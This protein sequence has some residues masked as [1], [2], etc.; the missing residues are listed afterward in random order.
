MT[1]GWKCPKCKYRNTERDN[2]RC[3]KCQE[4]PPQWWVDLRAGKPLQPPSATPQSPPTDASV[5]SVALVP[6]APAEVT[7]VRTEDLIHMADQGD[8]YACLVLAINSF[9][10]LGGPVDFK[11]S[12]S[13]LERAARSAVDSIAT[14]VAK[15]ILDL[16]A[17]VVNASSALRL[18]CPGHW[19]VQ[20]M[21]GGRVSQQRAF[22]HCWLMP[23]G[24]EKHKEQVSLIV[25]QDRAPEA[26]RTRL[27]DLVNKRGPRYLAINAQFA[28]GAKLAR[29]PCAIV[30]TRAQLEY[31]EGLRL[32]AS[33]P[34]EGSK[35]IG[36]AAKMGHPE[37]ELEYAESLLVGRG[38]D[39]DSAEAIV[40]FHKA[41]AR[42]D[43]VIPQYRLGFVLD[44]PSTMDNQPAEAAK[45][46]EMAAKAG[47][48]DA[49]LRLGR[50]YLEGRGV[51]VSVRQAVEWLSQ[52]AFPKDD[53]QGR[54]SM[55][56]ARFLLV[57]AWDRL[58]ELKAPL[59]V[60]E[61]SAQQNNSYSQLQL[62]WR[63]QLGVGTPADA[64]KARKWLTQA[65][66]DKVRPTDNDPAVLIA[67]ALL[68]N[69]YESMPPDKLATLVRPG[70]DFE[71]PMNIGT[72]AAG[73]RTVECTMLT[74]GSSAKPRV[75]LVAVEAKA[76]D[77]NRYVSEC[78]SLPTAED[79]STQPLGVTCNVNLIDAE[80]GLR[81]IIP[82]A[83]ITPAVAEEKIQVPETKGQPSAESQRI[84]IMRSGHHTNNWLAVLG[85]IDKIIPTLLKYLNR[86]WKRDI[87]ERNSG[88]EWLPQ[89]LHL[90]LGKPA[91]GDVYVG[92]IGVGCSCWMYVILSTPPPSLRPEIHTVFPVI[93]AKARKYYL[94][95]K[96]ILEWHNRIE[97]TMIRSAHF[98]ACCSLLR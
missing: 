30:V 44:D 59:R 7:P 70:I 49:Q 46:L 17:G 97:A 23:R 75:T 55:M 14:V 37:A 86:D 42:Q 39:Q 87:A 51:H 90:S 78:I 41:A 12:Q 22:V 19:F 48:V 54:E 6:L 61:T 67:K 52:A 69:D 2:S 8:P 82:F 35:H 3:F 73:R 45:W 36:E 98:L 74:R 88:L 10:G 40:W 32:R 9:H 96:Q 43:A 29:L 85:D 89:R 53:A 15:S 1:M 33:K 13:F 11:T 66:K 21:A 24:E 92:K 84:A 26:I 16:S 4:L 58:G 91:F 62:S 68:H 72:D 83:L 93:V 47:H 25:I 81:E 50:M 77:A 94:R 71:G 20:P 65:G 95:V 31:D 56:A 80:S 79:P 60:L 28:A 5:Q 27:A 76:D 63:Y 34:V 57:G 18:I 64:V 38:V